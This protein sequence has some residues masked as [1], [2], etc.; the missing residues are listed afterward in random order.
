MEGKSS[1]AR[2]QLGDETFWAPWL[3]ILPDEAELAEY[4]VAYAAAPGFRL[5]GPGV[6]LKPFH[7]PSSGSGGHEIQCR[8]TALAKRTRT[9]GTASA[10]ILLATHLAP[11]KM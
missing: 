10:I 5:S 2:L 11:V 8:A 1:G 7:G 3:R 6:S 9:R 4:H